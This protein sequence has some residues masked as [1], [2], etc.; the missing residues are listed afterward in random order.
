MSSKNN[1][2]L[3]AICLFAVF[4]FIHFLLFR[5]VVHCLEDINSCHT[6]FCV[7]WKTD[8]YFLDFHSLYYGMLPYIYSKASMHLCL[9]PEVCNFINHRPLQ[10]VVPHIVPSAL[11]KALRFLSHCTRPPPHHT[12][13]YFTCEQSLVGGC[14]REQSEVNMSWSCISP[15]TAFSS[16][17]E[18]KGLVRW[19][20]TF[21]V[22]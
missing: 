6:Y 13:L 22:Q 5:F 8:I 2:V 12:F 9:P 7:W 17:M 20:T 19:H 1:S 4:L 21:F 14:A 10:L 16:L 18:F 11:Q 15:Q 3:Q